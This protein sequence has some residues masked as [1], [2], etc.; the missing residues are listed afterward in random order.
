ME[1][2]KQMVRRSRRDSGEAVEQRRFAGVRVS[3]QRHR[4]RFTA[5]LALRLARPF[6]LLQFRFELA[7][8][9][10]HDAAVDLQLRL[11]DAS[12]A[13]AAGLTLE[14]RPLPRESRQHVLEL[15]Q[16]DLRTGLAA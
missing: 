3:D 10:S 2:G 15:C 12:G 8:A 7:D 1:S 5:R 4:E 11:T 6:D 13:D 16:L 9:R 14:V